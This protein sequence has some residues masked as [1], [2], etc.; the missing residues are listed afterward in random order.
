MFQHSAGVTKHVL[1]GFW[2]DL[3]SDCTD[4]MAETA[5]VTLF[6]QCKNE[7]I[8]SLLST[9]ETHQNKDGGFPV[10]AGEKSEFHSS[11]VSLWALTASAYS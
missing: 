1:D 10:F 11:L 4:L 3:F 5:A 8:L 2:F 7:E 9:L 6:C